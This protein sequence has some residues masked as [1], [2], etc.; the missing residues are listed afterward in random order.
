MGM[1]FGKLAKNLKRVQEELLRAQ[2]QAGEIEKEATSGGGAVKVVITGEYKLKS[3]TIDPEAVNPEEVEILQDMI[4]A[5][6]NQAV[7]ALGEDKENQMRELAGKL[8]L[9]GLPGL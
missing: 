7:E 6:V 3:V 5:A 1:G 8:G 4:V 9:P 2:E